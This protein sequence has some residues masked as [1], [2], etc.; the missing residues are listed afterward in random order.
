MTES[1]TFS[2]APF[3]AREAMARYRDLYSN[4]S[5][6]AEIGPDVS[7]DIKGWQLDRMI[8]FDRRIRGVG[9]ER[10]ANRVRRDQ[11]DHFTL[12]LNRGGEFH[13]EGEHGF[14]AVAAGELLLLDMSKPMRTRMPDAHIITVSLSREL[15]AAAAST[16][17]HLHGLILPKATSGLLSDFLISLVGHAPTLPSEAKP[18]ARRTLVELL[19]VALGPDG[20]PAE[21]ARAQLDAIRLDSA[22]RFIDAN[23]SDARLGP[24]T[25]AAAMGT[26]RA[27]IYRVFEEAGG[28]AKY[29]LARR[30]SRLRAALANP[31]EMRSFATLAHH[32]GFASESHASRVFQQMFGVRPAEFRQEIRF[33]MSSDYGSVA[34]LAKRKLTAWVSEF[35]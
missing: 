11:F 4:G 16:T 32:V 12:Q 6:T 34:A 17:D 13:G 9:A 7:A 28:V 23:L 21:P 30:L 35:R 1:L 24:D 2:T 20:A 29:I 3:P 8:L 25:V 27:T 26:S 19:H 10:A 22:R 14:R 5:D 31:G 18:A 15:V 33:S